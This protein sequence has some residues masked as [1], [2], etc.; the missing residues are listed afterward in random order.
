MNS[1]SSNDSVGALQRSYGPSQ[2]IRSVDRAVTLLQSIASSPVPPTV[3]DLAASCQLNRST[4]W[5]LLGTLEF[6]GLIARDLSTQGYV[7]GHELIRLASATDHESLLRR[8][9]PIIEQNAAKLEQT[10]TLAIAKGRDLVYVDQVDP[11]GVV[12]PSWIGKPISLHSTSSGKVFLA[13]LS[14]AEIKAIL[15]QS[16]ER[17]TSATITDAQRLLADLEAT[18]QRGYGICAGEYEEYSS[19]VAAPVFSSGQLI[20]IVAIWGPTQRMKDRALL[21]YGQSVIEVADELSAFLRASTAGPD[22]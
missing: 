10:L 9:R 12:R 17:F 1:V 22:L 15:P 5:R 7:L 13:S 6:H 19:G 4:A 21:R 11:P 8:A 3:T 16:L 2:R 14:P 18:R 20:A